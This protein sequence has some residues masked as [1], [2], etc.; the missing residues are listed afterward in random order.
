MKKVTYIGRR[1]TFKKNLLS[2]INTINKFHEKGKYP[3]MDNIKK[4]IKST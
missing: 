2:D 1:R 3:G 4:R